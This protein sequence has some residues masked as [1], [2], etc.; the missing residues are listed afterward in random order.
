MSAWK[1]DLEMTHRD[2]PDPSTFDLP[3]DLAQARMAELRATATHPMTPADE[4]G[5][6]TR[7]RGAV[8]RRL[9]ALG[10]SLVA[11]ETDRRRT[12]LG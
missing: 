1:G 6:L 3:F 4:L 12:V 9:I 5:S 10:S 7:L 11:D 8:G 2:R